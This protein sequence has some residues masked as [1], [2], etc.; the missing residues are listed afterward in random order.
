[1]PSK[2]ALNN[3]IKGGIETGHNRYNNFDSLESNDDLENLLEVISGYKDKKNN[4]P[5][6]TALCIVANPDFEKIREDDFEKYYYEPV[7]ET[8]QHYP[9]HNRVLDLW[10]EGSAQRLFVPQ[11]HGREHLNVQRWLRDLKMGNK[12]TLLGF[13]NRLWGINSQLIP[14]GY[15]AAFDLDKPTDLGY[16]KSVIEEGLDLFKKIMRYKARYFVAPNGPF[17]LDLEKVLYDNGIQ[18]ITLNKK[19]KEPLGNKKYKTH[20]HF[21]GKKNTY[22]Q[23]YLS[24]NVEFEPS[25]EG[26]DWVN[27]CLKDTEI[28][29]RMRKPAV[30]S[31]HRVNYTGS[32]DQKNRDRG[33]KQLSELLDRILKTWPEVEFLTSVELGNLVSNKPL[34]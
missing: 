30:I 20:Y 12:H 2:E 16:M 31:T 22:G 25:V 6:F 9:R 7:T 33:L 3:M 24:R 4:N 1:M 28:A 11:F 13:Q 23:I 10:R 18:F 5:V 29:F 14:E 19:H 27:K 26:I 17:N 32:L 15:L 21:P 8:L 34:S